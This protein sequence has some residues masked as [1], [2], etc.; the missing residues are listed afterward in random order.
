MRVFVSLLAL[1][2][3]ILIPII[4]VES[5][6]L[7]Y[8]F[9]VIIPYVAIAAFLLGITYRIVNWAR[10]PVPF[11]ITTT[12]GQQ[13]SLPWIKSNKLDSPHS[14]WGTIGRMALEVLFFRS[15]FRNT[16]ANVKSGPRLVYGPTKWLWFG[17][18]VFHYSFLII[19]LR[20]FRF[21]AEPVPQWV[22]WLQNIDGFFQVWLPSILLT[23]V[24]IV[25]ALTFLFVR[26]LW[27]DKL[28]Y[29]SLASDYFP[30]LLLLGI[31]GTGILMRYFTKTDLV[32][33][34]ELS[35]GL[36]GFSPVV[37]E[38]IGTMFF[39]HLFL[40]SI[41]FIYFPLSKLMHFAGVFLSPTRNLPNNN[42]S[43]RHV[44]PWD[45]PVKVHTYEEY[46]DEFRELMKA[47]DMPL[48][49]EE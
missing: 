34:K 5:L 19:F 30:L 1:G 41:L 40:V 48:E 32:A 49:K 14:R 45:H 2:V 21:F 47:A 24:A 27:D 42:R 37:P 20:H 39:I 9:G 7:H 17:A 12:S 43:E 11:R 15:L 23:N 6:G 16:R 18:L 36:I 3:L 29:F 44:N 22:M 25:A 10:S 26:R 28:R 35:M 38:G 4:G 33:I 46:E 13:T 31:A 8:L